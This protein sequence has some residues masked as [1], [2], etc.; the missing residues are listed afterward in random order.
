MS[1]LERPQK[2]EFVSFP[3]KLELQGKIEFIFSFIIFLKFTELGIFYRKMIRAG[4]MCWSLSF[5]AS[6]M[7]V[8]KGYE[9]KSSNKIFIV[10]CVQHNVLAP[11]LCGPHI[12]KARTSEPTHRTSS[13]IFT[14]SELVFSIAHPFGAS[15]PLII[16]L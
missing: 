6:S 12:R 3:K 16:L 15:T 9:S 10:F 1:K 4:P 2:V 13:V 11:K 5:R 8:A 14:F 7:W